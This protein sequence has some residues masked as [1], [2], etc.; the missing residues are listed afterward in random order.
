[1]LT[2]PIAALEI[3]RITERLALSARARGPEPTHDAQAVEPPM[4]GDA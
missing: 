2:G 3:R 1:M 4:W